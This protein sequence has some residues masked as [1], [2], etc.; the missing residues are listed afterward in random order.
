[1]AD[2]AADE[3][4]RRGAPWLAAAVLFLLLWLVLYPNLFV[5]FDSFVD[6]DGFT[7]RHYARFAGSRAEREALWNSVWISL[8]SVLLS[9]VIGV[10]LAFLFARR[11]HDPVDAHELADDRPHEP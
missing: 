7:L 11:L 9:G 1:M 6:R 10:P 8:A 2:P 5:L 3:T 4:R